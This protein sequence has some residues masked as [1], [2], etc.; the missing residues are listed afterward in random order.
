MVARAVVACV[1]AGSAQAFFMHGGLVP[2]RSSVGAYQAL[3]I[4]PMNDRSSSLPLHCRSGATVTN[5]NIWVFVGWVGRIL[6]VVEWAHILHLM[7]SIFYSARDQPNGSERCADVDIFASLCSPLF[8]LLCAWMQARCG[9]ANDDVCGGFCGSLLQAE[10]FPSDVSVKVT[11]SVKHP[12]HALQ[13]FAAY[14]HT[15]SC[16]HTFSAHASTHLKCIR[17]AERVR[18]LFR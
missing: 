17:K 15:F 10:N 5:G 16:L 18:C 6:C 1:L 4:S 7:L 14:V 8:S 9:R 12:K 13:R 2:L 3:A 11:L